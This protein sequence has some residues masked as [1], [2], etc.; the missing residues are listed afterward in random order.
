[1]D[2]VYAVFFGGPAVGHRDSIPG[3]WAVANPTLSKRIPP[4]ARKTSPIAC[5]PQRPVRLLRGEWRAKLVAEHQAPAIVRMGTEGGNGL[6]I[7]G[8]PSRPTSF[9]WSRDSPDEGPS[10]RHA[11]LR[12]IHVGPSQTE[13]LTEVGFCACAVVC[14]RE[15]S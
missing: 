1:L 11:P 12:Q 14:P 7:Q 5:A 4:D 10:Y 9:G 15:R 13:H 2:E 6:L 3:L 8:D